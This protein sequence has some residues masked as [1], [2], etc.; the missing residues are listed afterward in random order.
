VELP[1]SNSWLGRGRIRTH[2]VIFG[3]RTRGGRAFDLALLIAILLSVVA[4]M[5]E[6]VEPVSNEYG[7]LLL[8]IEWGFTILFT[9]EYALRLLCVRRPLKYATSF[10]GVVDLLAI[11]PT[12]L[13]LLMPGTALQSLIVIRGL[14]LLRVFRVLKLTHLIR[15]GHSLRDA[16]WRARDMVVVFLLTVFCVVVI[17]GAL[18]Y[19]VEGPTN[20]FTSIPQGVYWAIVT[21]TTVGYGD[22]VPQ[23]PLGKMLS[24]LLIILGYALIVVPTGFVSA[25]LVGKDTRTCPKCAKRGHDEDALH[26]RICGR[27]LEAPKP[28]ERR[29]GF[30]VDSA[31]QSERAA[32]DNSTL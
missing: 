15:E 7:R 6:T 9:L 28:D 1:A 5:L 29:R 32:Q 21:M 11:L 19:L 2:K 20:G 13:T 16:V 14:R 8:G 17:V 23:T 12:Y 26:C 3:H 31:R 30:E 10:F 18:M 4:V 27:R 22:V 24:T 25:S